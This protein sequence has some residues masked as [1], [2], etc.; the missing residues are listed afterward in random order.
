MTRTVENKNK[1]PIKELHTF[2]TTLQPDCSFLSAVTAVVTFRGGGAHCHRSVRFQGG[3]RI[4]HALCSLRVSFDRLSGTQRAGECS[5][6]TW[7]RLGGSPRA[8]AGSHPAQPSF[9]LRQGK[10]PV[11]PALSLSAKQHTMQKC[12]QTWRLSHRQL[13]RGGVINITPSPPS[14]T[15]RLDGTQVPTRHVCLD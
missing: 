1:G 11:P 4:L 14:A 12:C 9:C 6:D 13:L 3:K 7:G 8:G 5:S 10:T 15:C 2:P